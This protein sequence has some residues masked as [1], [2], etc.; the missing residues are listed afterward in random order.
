MPWGE[1]AVL[2][3]ALAEVSSFFVIWIS[4]SCLFNHVITDERRQRPSSL[5]TSYKLLTPASSP[6]SKK[7]VTAQSA[8]FPSLSSSSTRSPGLT[9]SPFAPGSSSS[10]CI[11]VPPPALA[12]PQTLPQAP[13]E[14]VGMQQPGAACR[15]HRQKLI[16]HK[17]PPLYKTAA[18]RW[19]T[20]AAPINLQ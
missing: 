7:Q 11:P 12:P 10:T 14:A 16:F 15:D 2:T 20:V 4:F 6:S 3:P 17:Q 1:R 19:S 5:P 18:H 9:K 13:K 8:L